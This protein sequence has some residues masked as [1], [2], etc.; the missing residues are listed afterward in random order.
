MACPDEN[1]LTAMIAHSG[2]PG[3]FADLEAHIDSCDHCRK[4]VAAAA[5]AETLAM[6]TPEPPGSDEPLLDLSV[7]GRYVIEALLGRGG[8]GSV[9]LARDVTLGRE[10]ALK[11]HRAGSGGERL[12]REAVAM[13][14]LAHPNVVTVFEVTSIDD[15]LCVAMEY[16]RG[17]TLRGWRGS[18]H[19]T[20]HEIVALLLDAGQGLAAAHAAGLVHRDFKPENVLVGDDGR[21]RVG[22]FGLARVGPEPAARRGVAAALA[23]LDTPMTATGTVLGTP[24]YMAPEQLAGEPVDARCDQFAFC[25]VAWECLFGRRP[26]TGNSL[27]AIRTAIVERELAAPGKRAVPDRVRR[28]IERGLATE[29]ADRYADMPE[30]LATL[31]A[32]AAPR[33]RRRVAIA[34]VALVAIGG[35]AL[36]AA[37]TLSSRA[38]EA[39]CTAQGDTVR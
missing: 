10:V 28:A 33:T 35:G 22:D 15:R 29:P 39:A 26:F 4:I 1:E 8:M 25:V 17:D 7:G 37:S 2:A 20:W 34:A 23:D 11:L 13:A 18:R 3:A 6:G 30:L 36:A 31:R 12:H 19:R 24:A 32:A 5:R 38:R 14:K 21:P 27:A 9:Y 16:V